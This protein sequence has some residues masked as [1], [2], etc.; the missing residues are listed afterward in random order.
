MV[1]GFGAV[2]RVVSWNALLGVAAVAV[3]VGA[4]E[5]YLRLTWPFAQSSVE[6][7]YVSGVGYLLK[8]HSE[9]R[10]T[11]WLDYWTTSRANSLG[12]LDREPPAPERAESGCHVAV[13]GDSFIE[14]KEVRVADKVQVR[15]EAMA[16]E[17]VPELGVVTSGWGWRGT[18]QVQQLVWWDEWI[19]RRL[20]RLVVLVFAYNDLTDNADDRPDVARA[21]RTESGIALQAPPAA[22]SLQP[23]RGW[24]RWL[25]G[26][27]VW[28]I[29]PPMLGLWSAVWVGRKRAAWRR[30]A[31]ARLAPPE[32][33]PLTGSAVSPDELDL[34]GFGIDQWQQRVRSAG[35]SLVVLSSHDVSSEPLRSALA[36]L[37]ADRGVPLVDQADYIARQGGDLRHANWPND[38][39][40]TPQGHEWAAGALLE[41][42]MANRSVCDAPTATKQTHLDRAVG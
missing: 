4:A 18:G 14:A 33:A 13:V 2:G 20:P 36:K 19:E 31:D 3:V 6:V 38:M 34:T 15:L 11:N 22:A 1:H 32:R 28:E 5:A 10:W 21:R 27:R 12:F 17:A 7:E 8:P 37:T 40:W 30:K 39:H 26:A 9:V 42:L 41:W 16:A 25:P 23:V 24:R 35:A 29:H